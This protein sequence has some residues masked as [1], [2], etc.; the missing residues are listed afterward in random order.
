[1]LP[2]LHMYVAFQ[3]Q[4][5][6][7]QSPLQAQDIQIFLLSFLASFLFLLASIS[8]SYHCNVKPLPLIVFD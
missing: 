6:A 7:F 4:V 1:M 5:E 8:A 2:D 3:E